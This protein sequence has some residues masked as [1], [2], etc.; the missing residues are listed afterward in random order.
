MVNTWQTRASID[1]VPRAVSTI[2]VGVA[3]GGPGVVH[4]PG[5]IVGDGLVD[6]VVLGW[7]HPTPLEDLIEGPLGVVLHPLAPVGVDREAGGVVHLGVEDVSG[8]VGVVVVR[9]DA[10]TGHLAYQLLTSF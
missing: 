3:V 10:D 2:V 7:C 6:P 5:H 9:G 4:R 1:R 8:G